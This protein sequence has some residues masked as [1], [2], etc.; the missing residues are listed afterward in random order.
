M[1]LSRSSESYSE[2]DFQVKRCV[3]L[4]GPKT[5]VTKVGVSVCANVTDSEQVHLNPKYFFRLNK[6]L[7]LFETY[8]AFL[9]LILTFL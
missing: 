7:H 3:A 4:A 2:R 5:A 6:S 1:S 9:N 8:F